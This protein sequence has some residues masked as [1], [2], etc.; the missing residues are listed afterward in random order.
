MLLSST[1]GFVVDA[2]LDL[3]GEE[4]WQTKRRLGQHEIDIPDSITTCISVPQSIHNVDDTILGQALICEVSGRPFRIVAMELAFYR[5][6][7]LPLPRRHP[8]IRH[9][10]RC[11]KRPGRELYLRTCNKTGEQIV[12]VYPE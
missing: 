2:V 11:K 12:S 8:D 7:Q 3:G 10:E 6:H 1:E 4:I 9:T 5:R